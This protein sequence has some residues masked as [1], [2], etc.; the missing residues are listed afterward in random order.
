[1]EY[2]LWSGPNVGH[3]GGEDTNVG[4]L[5]V[6][7]WLVGCCWR[8]R[9]SRMHGRELMKNK[10]RRKELAVFILVKGRR[11]VISLSRLLKKPCCADIEN[12]PFPFCSRR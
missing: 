4:E 2:L 5:H 1:M 3:N 12:A 9:R 7:G 6:V 11:I 8:R 10:T